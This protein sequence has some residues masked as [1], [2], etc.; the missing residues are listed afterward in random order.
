MWKDNHD[1]GHN[2]CQWR[3]TCLYSFPKNLYSFQMESNQALSIS[4]S[5]LHRAAELK[6]RIDELSNELASLLT[7]QGS[8]P[9]GVKRS[10]GGKRKMSPEG[11]ARIAAAARARW[12]KVHAGKDSPKFDSNSGPGAGKKRR[13]MS[14]AARKKIAEAAKARWARI[15][16][17]KGK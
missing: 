5:D 1:I 2:V 6:E 17:A 16:A 8:A 4:S 11:R 13:K 9:S 14:P 12:A 15:R 10:Q 7:G 3:Q